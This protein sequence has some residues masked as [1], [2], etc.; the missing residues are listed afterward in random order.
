MRVF[1]ALRDRLFKPRRDHSRDPLQTLCRRMWALL[2]RRE[3]RVVELR[4]RVF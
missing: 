1:P 2:D 3:R 4:D